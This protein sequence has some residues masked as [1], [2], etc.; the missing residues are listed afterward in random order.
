MAL[1]SHKK[2]ALVA[3]GL[4]LLG[5]FAG[6]Y[7]AAEVIPF[8]YPLRDAFRQ[9]PFALGLDLVGGT[10][11]VYEADVEKIPSADRKDALEGVRD[12][13]ERRV[14][15]LGATEPVIQTT[16][17]GEDWRV[18]VE[19][20]GIQDVKQAIDRIGETPLLEF[21]EVNTDPP[22]P[23]TDAQRKQ[24][25]EENT[26]AKKKANDTLARLKTGTVD[27]LA[28][29]KELSQDPASKET[30]GDIGVVSADTAGRNELF[31]AA[32]RAGVGKLAASVVENSEGYN[33]VRVEERKDIEEVEARHILICY[34]GATR[35]EKT[36]SKDDAKKQVEALRAQATAA[37][38]EQ[39]AKD[40][41]TEPGAATSGGDLGW[42]RRGVMVKAFEDAAFPLAKGAISGVIETEFG[43][44]I[45]LKNDER[46]VPAYA[47]RRILFT[48]TTEEAVRPTQ[49][50]WKAT[51]LSGRH[52][53]RAQLQFDQQSGIPHVGVTFNDEG[54]RLFEEL[55]ASHVG[56]QIA[57]FLDGEVISAP[58]VNEKIT[59]GE[60]VITG[61]FSIDE[62]RLLA[63]RLNAGALPVPI[64]LESQTTVG[65][66]LGQDSLTKSLRAG[67]AGLLIV[68][69]F[70]IAY[71][72]VSG[73]M[74][75]LALLVY[76]ALLLTVFRLL[77]VTLTLSGVAGLVLSIGMAVDANILVSSRMR[78]ELQAGK[79]LSSAVT[80][81]FR[82]AW[83]SIRDG[84]V[85][86]LFSAA[87]L[88]W[89]SSSSMRGF[90]LVLGLGVLMS[91]F[92]ALVVTKYFIM[93]SSHFLRNRPR[94]MV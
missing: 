83:P 52:L 3:G 77:P 26:A 71:Y 70:M 38:F 79:P 1:G 19:L 30:G 72:R 59:G 91:I 74:A 87:I 22:V 58:T 27:F 46:K 92:S 57:I 90:G 82:R 18:I 15:S 55:T 37:N 81:G 47:L 61:S 23:L 84:N 31:T 28:L 75:V 89:F 68:A 54:K 34:E 63:Q 35:C 10:H 13:I 2:A 76:T 51:A 41:S 80:E 14:N 88:F 25:E 24:I 8:N 4:L 9:R 16:R 49:D 56:K 73:L 85:T 36:T 33:I 11:L 42:F 94:W 67:L 65:P 43:F 69:L 78:E 12:V 20:A 48:K 6:A 53:E 62:A 32:E 29:A 40:N 64:T 86:T 17:A 44:H 21:K 45:I 60:A 5:I 66:I 93:F 50:P 39:L 7:D